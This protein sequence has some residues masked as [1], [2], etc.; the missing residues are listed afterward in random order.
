MVKELLVP[1]IRELLEQNDLATITTV[2]AEMHPAAAGELLGGLNPD[3]IARILPTLPLQFQAD[4]FSHFEMPMQVALVEGQGR[5][6]VARLLEEMPPDDRAD[7]IR[8]LDEQVQRELMPLLAQAERADIR[9]LT[10]Y[11]EDSVGAVMTTDYATVPED[12]TAGE[13]LERLRHAAP[14]AETIYY[15]YV[16]DAERHLKGVFS[17]KTLILAKPER[18]ISSLMISDVQSVRV[19][20]DRETVAQEVAKYDWLAM[21]VVD[22]VGRL[23]G[24]VTVD[25]VI[26]VIEDEADEDI[27][28]LG[29]AGKP[30]DGYF[31]VGALRMA[32]QRL[33]WLLLLVLVGFVTASVVKAFGRLGDELALTV[34]AFNTMLLGSGGNASTQTTTVIV[35]GLATGELTR[36][37]AGRVFRKEL[38]VALIA[39]VA[40]AVL[41]ATRVIISD[42]NWALALTVAL[43]MIATIII[44]KSLGGMLPLVM[45]RIGL[46]PA[47]M[48]APLITTILDV[49]TLTVYLLLA[50]AIMLHVGG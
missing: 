26:D 28:H 27:Y 41:A 13:A 30:L 17:L 35:R 21:P 20:D 5:G 8:A 24:L 34:V 40:L 42:H 37:D 9:R 44:A 4:V 3:E 15:V 48:S 1:E 16:T 46:D 38:A 6:Q 25:D 33:P 2:V 14:D 29:A 19:T 23:V 18:K 39:G 11:P 10:S 22:D 32:W 47:L 7:L 49:V 31:Q 12:I 45:D 50:M 36:K 43:A